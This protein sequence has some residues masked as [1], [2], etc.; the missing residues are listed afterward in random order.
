MHAQPMPDNM[1]L[2]AANMMARQL[3]D[4]FMEALLGKVTV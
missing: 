4:I 1:A 3:L 2:S